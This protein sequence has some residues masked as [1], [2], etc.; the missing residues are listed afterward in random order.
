MTR[1]FTTTLAGKLG[2]DTYHV[3]DAGDVV[4]EGV[5]AGVETVLAR[6][7]RRRPPSTT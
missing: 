5:D 7:A 6:R 4:R 1:R 2:N 3:D